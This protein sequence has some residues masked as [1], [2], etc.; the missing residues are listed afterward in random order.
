MIVWKQ[1]PN[2]LLVFLFVAK[3]KIKNQWAKEV[4]EANDN[5]LKK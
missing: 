5:H 1:K 4:E 3:L 2:I